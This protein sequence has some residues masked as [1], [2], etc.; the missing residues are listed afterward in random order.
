M[1]SILSLLLVL[2]MSLLVVRIATVALTLTGLSQPLARFQ[3]RS[4]F[5]GAGFTTAESEKVMKHPVR[6]R[7]ILLLM[8]LGNAGIITAVSSLILTF[9]RPS[10]G[11][12]LGAAWFRLTVLG[13]GVALLWLVAH[14][15]W[16]DRQLS[17]LIEIAL[18]RWTDLE[19]RDYAGL[20]HLS[21]DYSVAEL[22][23]EPQDWL[24]GHVLRELRLA[25]EGVIVLG[26]EKLSGAYLGAPR[27]QTRL[28]AGDT[29]ILYGP[30]TT[31]ANLDVRRGGREGIAEHYEAVDRQREAVEQEE[32]VQKEVEERSE[33]DEAP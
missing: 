2:V 3:A 1:I 19:V 6:R 33:T 32:A 21:G 28:D 17:R 13:V 26:V 27:G 30:R 14:S 4:A 20:L 16:V 15:A 8:L 9:V 22:N 25:D 29:L 31:L 12:L 18:K 5:T 10:S 7:V 24:A 23:V 11:G